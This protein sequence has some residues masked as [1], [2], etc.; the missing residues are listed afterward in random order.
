MPRKPDDLTG[1]RFKKLLVISRGASY[2]G[3]GARWNCLCDCGKTK[4]IA[5]ATLKNGESGSCGCGR[6]KHRMTG[7]REHDAWR[8]MRRRC[9]TKTHPEFPNYGGR[10]ILICAR[11]NDF[12]SFYA[13]MGPAP[14]GLSL[15][16]IDVNGHYCPENCK[17]G[18]TAEQTRNKRVN[19]SITANGK[20]MCLADWARELGV[21]RAN[22]SSRLKVGWDPVK[23]VTTPF[24]N[25]T[26]RNKV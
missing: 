12:A 13:D 9:L 20:T 10:G 7:S 26:T 19:H 4:L 23:A 24:S 17:W 15:E 22:I 18:T 8:N 16:R 25:L 6:E 1:Q 5:A 21:H 3:G 2:A 14:A 11:W